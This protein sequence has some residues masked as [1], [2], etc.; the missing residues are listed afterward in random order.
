MYAPRSPLRS[1]LVVVFITLT[2]SS[3]CAIAQPLDTIRASPNA[4]ALRSIWSLRGDSTEGVGSQVAALPDIDA[5]GRSEFAVQGF[6]DYTWRV[7]SFD[8]LG[9]VNVVWQRKAYFTRA[10]QGWPAVWTRRHDGGLSA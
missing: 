9:D 3:T 6:G 1:I 8:A 4:V 2:L 10:D 5:D 7:Y